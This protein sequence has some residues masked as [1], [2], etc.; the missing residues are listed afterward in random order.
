VGPISW[1]KLDNSGADSGAN[2]AAL[3]ISSGLA[4]IADRKNASLSALEFGA[5]GG[6][7]VV[8]APKIAAG[9]NF[10]FSFWFK[11]A[12]KDTTARIL[13]ATPGNGIFFSAKPTTVAFGIGL[14]AAFSVSGA[15][16]AG[17]W[18]H[19]AGVY[20]GKNALLYVNGRLAGTLA[21]P[22]SIAGDLTGLRFGG[23]EA[24]PWSGTLDDI[25]IYKRVLTAA[26]IAKIYAQ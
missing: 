5:G 24:A 2:G 26:E 8:A 13:A 21:A 15:F 16:V 9:S 4:F 12:G 17:Q 10:T 23:P 18:T 14:P 6:S 3:A 25:R 22:G 7:A 11:Y 19:A 20:D 1:Y